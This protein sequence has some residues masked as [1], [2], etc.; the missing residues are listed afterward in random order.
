[1]AL[2][3]VRWGGVTVD[4]TDL[5]PAQLRGAAGGS[6]GAALADADGRDLIYRLIL[7]GTQAARPVDGD[8]VLNELRD[9]VLFEQPWAWL[10]RVED[11]TEISIG[12]TDADLPPLL[13]ALNARYTSVIHDGA[14][15]ELIKLATP[16][17][18]DPEEDRERMLI[19]R[20][21]LALAARHLS[22]SEAGQS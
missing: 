14:L 10:D 8:L 18:Q 7:T 13:T 9:S 6:V 22:N 17:N 20:D 12:D 2:D 1:M 16:E 3:T 5:G 19:A 15:D 11:L 21:A 4:G